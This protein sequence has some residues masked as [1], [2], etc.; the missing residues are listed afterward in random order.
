MDIGKYEI[1]EEISRA[2]SGVVFKARD[3]VLNRFVAI[4]IFSKTSA[5][6]PDFKT[7]FRHEVQRAAV[8]YHPNLVAVYDSGELNGESFLVMEYL[9]SGSLQRLIQKDGPIEIARAKLIL[10]DLGNGLSFAHSLNVTHGNLN[11]SNILFDASGHARISEAGFLSLLQASQ[12]QS[13]AVKDWINFSPAYAAPELWLGQR[14]TFASDI[15]SLAC[16]VVEMIS[17]KALFEGKNIEELQ[18]SHFAPPNLPDNLPQS[19]KNL[20]EKALAKRPEDRFESIDEFVSDLLKA[21]IDDY[22]F[23]KRDENYQGETIIV[24]IGLK[25]PE[26]PE[27][28]GSVKEG[29][30]KPADWKIAEDKNQQAEEATHSEPAQTTELDSQETKHFNA[31]LAEIADKNEKKPVLVKPNKRKTKLGVIA[32]IALLLIILGV[33][34]YQMGKKNPKV[35]T[36]PET[37]KVVV[38]AANTAAIPTEAE[39]TSPELIPTE[40][41]TETP[42]PTATETILGIGSTRIREMD[43]MEQVY[44]PAGDFIM[45]SENGYDHERPVRTVYLDSYWIDK[46]EVTNGQYQACVKNGPCRLLQQ[47]DSNLRPDYYGNSSYDNYPVIF[48]DWRQAKAYCEWAGGD[49]PTEAQWEK[50]ARGTDGREYPWGNEEPDK[51]YANFDRDIGDTSEVGRYVKGAS[52]YGAMDMAGNVWEWVNDWYGDYDVNDTYNPMGND[53]GSDRITRGGSWYMR[54]MYIKTAFRQS[55]EPD[56][57]YSGLGFRCVTSP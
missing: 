5:N 7:E 10:E 41:A 11:P 12:A 25:P 19:W 18:A 21:N 29:I 57:K 2:E 46:Y 22:H 51:N 30:A 55:R 33:I 38:T 48:V 44:V 47:S 43:G 34:A 37:V 36:E 53:H 23:I 40:A 20:L 1:L 14:P 15:Y 42:E 31:G 50:A 56:S 3:T 32:L 26:S 16:I 27:S 45:G 39:A 35:E 13:R 17:G 4:K 49:L 54:T 8:R 6:N 9:P 52:P 24:P 28:E